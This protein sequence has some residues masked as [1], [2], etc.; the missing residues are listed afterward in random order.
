MNELRCAPFNVLYLFCHLAQPWILPPSLQNS[1][2]PHLDHG[3]QSQTVAVSSQ[4]LSSLGM[5][6]SGC[7]A[8]CSLEV[9]GPL[10][11]K[12]CLILLSSPLKAFLV[13]SLVL[14]V[15]AH[16]RIPDNAVIFL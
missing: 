13:F 16:S 3:L 6:C 12:M 11:I 2:L 10:A 4:Q 8:T 9:S 14:R 7:I 1:I 15:R 5:C